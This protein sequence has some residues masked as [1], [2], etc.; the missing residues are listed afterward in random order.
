MKL[1]RMAFVP[2]ALSLGQAAT[3]A[4]FDYSSPGLVP[5]TGY[6]TSVGGIT[7]TV[8]ASGNKLAYY[9]LAPGLGNSGC[10]FGICS[11]AMQNTESLTLSFSQAVTMT[12]LKIA[13]WDSADT[14]SLAASNGNTSTLSNGPLFATTGAFNLSGLGQLTS[15]TITGASFTSVFS[16]RGMDVTPVSSVPV[17]AAAWL[18]GSGLLGLSGFARRLK[19]AA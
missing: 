8:T 4:T 14:I 5:S 11:N 6:S 13:A 18:F 15:L 7:A 1:L 9:A 3:A 16:L 19:R 10:Y 2:L 12:Q 17:P